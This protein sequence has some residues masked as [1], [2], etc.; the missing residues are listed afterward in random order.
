MN[1]PHFQL[2]WHERFLG[3]YR[4]LRVGAKYRVVNGPSR[5]A[6]RFLDQFDVYLQR[7]AGPVSLLPFRRDF[8]LIEY[9][10]PVVGLMCWAD[11]GEGPCR[12][13]AIWLLGRIRPLR[14]VSVIAR[15]HNADP[16]V[17]RH[18]AKALWRMEAWAL[19]RELAA[20]DPDPVVRRIAEHAA[21]PPADFQSRL[22]RY[23]RDEVHSKALEELPRRE[24]LQLYLNAV[25]GVG[26]PP[27]SP[28]FI[29]MILERIRRLVRG[30][31]SEGGVRGA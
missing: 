25:P 16:H 1:A 8:R 21:R 26:L 24:R 10:E 15:C 27:K 12:T 28:A 17:R 18:A 13:I 23:V 6:L 9:Y 14:D 19:L 4:V 22:S 2:R 31:P 30:D 20:D 11:R 7:A 29:R 3:E 5:A